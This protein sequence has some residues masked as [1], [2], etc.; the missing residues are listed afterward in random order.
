MMLI[1][2]FNMRVIFYMIISI[3]ESFKGKKKYGK[4]KVQ[5]IYSYKYE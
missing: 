1:R 4:K 2:K 5:G 3:I